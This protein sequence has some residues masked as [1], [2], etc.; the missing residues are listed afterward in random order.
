MDKNLSTFEVCGAGGDPVCGLVFVL[1]SDPSDLEY[2][3]LQ[4]RHNPYYNVLSY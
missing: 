1:V 4:L 3:V 2:G